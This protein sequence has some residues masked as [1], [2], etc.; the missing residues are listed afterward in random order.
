MKQQRRLNQCVS[1][2]KINI[3]K[4]LSRAISYAFYKYNQ[5][6]NKNIK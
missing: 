1:K 6:V 5:S 4:S 3:L 2:T